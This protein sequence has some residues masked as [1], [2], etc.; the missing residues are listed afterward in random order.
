MREAREGDRAGERL[1]VAQ[2]T[3]IAQHRLG[4]HC[5]THVSLT[6]NDTET[7]AGDRHWFD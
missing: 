5:K 3:R 4:C 6:K 1:S 7:A 2:L